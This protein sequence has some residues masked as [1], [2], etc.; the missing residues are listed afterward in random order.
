MKK[1]KFLGKVLGAFVASAMFASSVTYASESNTYTVYDDNGVAYVL[2]EGEVLGV[3]YD[4][5]GNVKEQSVIS[6]CGNY[7]SGS[8]RTLAPGEHFTTYQY[9][10]VDSFHAGFYYLYGS[11]LT[12]A[13][14]PGGELKIILQNSETIGGVRNDVKTGIFDTTYDVEDIK[15]GLG[16]G[17]GE[18]L[19]TTIDLIIMH[20]LRILVRKP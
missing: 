8:K 15:D 1:T 10:P 5:Y 17:V 6:P 19:I 2:N 20:D 12:P 13:T 4:K 9:E 11:E 7:V 3:L 18:I 16:G 14:T